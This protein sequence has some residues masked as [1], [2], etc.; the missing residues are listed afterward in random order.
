MTLNRILGGAFAASVVTLLASAGAQAQTFTFAS[1]FQG[2]PSPAINS[3]SAAS[4][5]VFSDT[6]AN[7]FVTGTDPSDATGNNAPTVI[8][9]TNLSTTSSTPNAT[10]DSF[11][12]R[13]YAIALTLTNQNNGQSIT[14]TLTGAMSG[15]ASATSGAFTNVFN[16]SSLVYIFGNGNQFTVSNFAFNSP[17]APGATS[18][19]SI[20][21]IVSFNQNV[22]GA[23]EPGSFALVAPAMLGVVGIAARRRKKS[24]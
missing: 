14:Q 12:N 7:T 10:P 3:V 23:P 4:N 24:A 13:V 20:N 16:Q 21:G 9:L 17:G 11:T 5:Q 2:E 19:G 8:V 18:S 6:N 22:V 1:N 15:S